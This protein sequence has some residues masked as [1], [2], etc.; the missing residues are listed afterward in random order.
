MWL[1]LGLL[2]FLWTP[3]VAVAAMPSQIVPSSCD[4]PHCTCDD[5]VTLASNIFN[6]GIY[7]AVFLTG[8]L[9][10]YAGFKYMTNLETVGG[11]KDAKDLI[12]KVGIGF[13]LILSAWII[14]DTVLGD[15]TS[16]SSFKVVWHSICGG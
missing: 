8:I 9:F 4:G 11:R 13:V 6:T 7:L 5:L 15:I 16:G 2:L 10:M 1:H 14:V 3:I 12:F